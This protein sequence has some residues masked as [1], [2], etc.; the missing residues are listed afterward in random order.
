VRVAICLVLSCA[1]WHSAPHEFAG[2]GA[3]GGAA[4]AEVR[5]ETAAEPGR[6]HPS[7]P[8]VD[9][10]DVVYDESTGQRLTVIRP[11]GDELLPTIVYFHGGAWFFG[12]RRDVWSFGEPFIAQVERGWAVV[13]VDVRSRGSDGLSVPVQIV[14]AQAAL[15]W[16]RSP[17]GA[18]LGLDG[19]RLVLAGTSSGGHVAMLVAVRDSRRFTEDLVDR[20][21]PRPGGDVWPIRGVVAQAAPTDLS[22]LTSGVL[23]A[24]VRQLVGCEPSAAGC[25]ARM[26]RLSPGGQYGQGVPRL[27]LWHGTADDVVPIEGTRRFV[28]DVRSIGGAPD[29]WLVEVSGARHD[30]S[31]PKS[32]ELELFLWWCAATAAG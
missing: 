27:F 25:A 9:V 10:V 31:L 32:Y 15:A 8:A 19:R 23:A 16:V 6:R 14:D 1:T 18:R 13:S 29:V 20:R 24:A 7:W 22:S 12:D 4:A 26:R 2:A 3:R 30:A 21:W 11:A 28:D 17:A 5:P